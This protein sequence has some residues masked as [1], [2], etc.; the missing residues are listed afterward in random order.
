LRGRNQPELAG[1]K[2]RST[3]GSATYSAAVPVDQAP[4]EADPRSEPPA[5]PA[6]PQDVAL[7][8]H[9]ARMAR[10]RRIYYPAIAAVAVAVL[11]IS[12]VVYLGGENAHVSS[13]T[14]KRQLPAVGIQPLGSSL[15][16]AWSNADA[17]ADG[18]PVQGGILVTYAGHTVTG[19]SALTGVAQWR[20]T[21]SGRDICDVAQQSNRTVILYLH[22]GNC[23]EVVAVDSTTGALVWTRTLDQNGAPIDGRA[24]VISTQDTF[25]VWTG[26]AAYAL[27]VSGNPCNLS[28]GVNCGI[29]YWDYEPQ[30]NCTILA[31]SL[32]AVG[33]FIDEQC[34]DG[35]HL[36]LRDRYAGADD[37]NTRVLWRTTAMNHAV[38]PVAGDSY[39]VAV[40]PSGQ[41]LTFDIRTGAL[42]GQ[43]SFSAPL[44]GTILTS[45]AG[46]G[47]SVW[48]SGTTYALGQM[49]QRSWVQR[50]L[51]L[52]QLNTDDSQLATPTRD[53]LANLST[54][55]GAV[56]RQWRLAQPL[57]PASRLIRLGSGYVAA[58][59]STV[60]LTSG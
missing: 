43:P 3:P 18:S 29:D 19:R 1:G 58:A 15:K 13:S 46:G 12:I 21:W 34:A 9:Q 2:P 17:T 26:H 7:A 44:P 8:R 20:F 59:R 52:P 42:T 11:V 22:A 23:D 57:D 37:K 45:T 36:V 40:D 10:Q 6:A 50:T 48:A 27:Q 25:L 4:A 54:A 24:R 32:A 41:L 35:Y 49:G 28:Q 5:P 55:N 56:V 53:G 38:T 60:V 14:T 51:T 39:A 16:V 47:V 31:M 33:A 30:K